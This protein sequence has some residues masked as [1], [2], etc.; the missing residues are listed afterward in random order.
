MQDGLPTWFDSVKQATREATNEFYNFKEA[1]IQVLELELLDLMRFSRFA[2][3]GFTDD[4]DKIRD[5]L[6]ALKKERGDYLTGGDDGNGDNAGSEAKD[7]VAEF[8]DGIKEGIEKESARLDLEALGLSEALIDQ[9]LGSQG[10]EELFQTITDGGAEMARQLQD[11]FEL[12]AAGMAELDKATEELEKELE[13]LKQQQEDLQ[14]QIK[15]T[16]EE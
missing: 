3:E 6:I 12:T 16:Q 10:W 4:I 11:D 5:G 8:F 15:D 14:Q 2:P 9:I 7:Y 1:G 13:D